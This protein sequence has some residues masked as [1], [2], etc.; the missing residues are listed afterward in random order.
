MIEPPQ[1]D[2]DWFPVPRVAMRALA[3]DVVAIG[4]YA[5]CLERMRYPGSSAS[6]VLAIGQC[7]I[8]R[9]EVATELGTT[10]AKI[11][12]ALIAIETASLITS[13]TT[14]HGTIVT[15]RGYAESCARRDAKPPAESPSVSASTFTSNKNQ[16]SELQPNNTTNP[17]TRPSSAGRGPRGLGTGRSPTGSGAAPRIIDGDHSDQGRGRDVCTHGHVVDLCPQCEP[18]WKQVISTGRTNQ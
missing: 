12:R 10:P 14:N 13:K 7:F 1:F 15:V 8:G 9:D 11:R 3:G 16:I 6:G 4:L 2:T 5:L 17:T 18:I